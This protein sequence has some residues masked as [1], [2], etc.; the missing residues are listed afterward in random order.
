MTKL[1]KQLW[2]NWYIRIYAYFYKRIDNKLD[3]EELTITTLEIFF[4]N[5]GKIEN[6]IAFIFKTARN[7][8]L[9]YFRSKKKLF[10]NI[11]DLESKLYYS[12]NYK[13]KKSKLLECAE[14]YLEKENLEIVEMCIMEDFSG[15]EVAKKTNLKEATVRQ[16]LKRSLD[17]IRKNCLKIWLKY[18]S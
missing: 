5:E 1:T 18:Q 9:E 8:I 6:E 3:C 7:K 17:K 4:L 15:K 11:E 13:E 16:R 10:L 14:K 12:N 2:D